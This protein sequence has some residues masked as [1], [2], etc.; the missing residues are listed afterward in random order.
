MSL[1]KYKKG[2]CSNCSPKGSLF[3]RSL[4]YDHDGPAEEGPRP[5]WRCTNCGH[6]TPRLERKSSERTEPTATQTKA[7]GWLK[8]AIVRLKS[9]KPDDSEF[10]EE[11]IRVERGVLY[12]YLVFGRKGD[13]GTL[14]AIVGR[15]TYHVA[16][17]PSGSVRPVAWTGPKCKEPRGVFDVANRGTDWKPPKKEPTKS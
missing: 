15:E 3:T 5:V 14:L 2:P 4:D 7:L 12:A 1:A 10:K 16:I 11:R 13:E 17:G 9:L 8:D 6:E